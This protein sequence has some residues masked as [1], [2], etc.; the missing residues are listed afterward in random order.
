VN[1][2][3]VSAVFTTRY[4]LQYLLHFSVNLPQRLWLGVLVKDLICK[5]TLTLVGSAIACATKLVLNRKCRKLRL[6]DWKNDNRRDR[7]NVVWS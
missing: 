4:L 1:S 7:R 2:K 5:A 3:M 6:Y